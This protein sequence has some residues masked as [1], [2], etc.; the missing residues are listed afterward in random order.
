[1]EIFKY[2]LALYIFLAALLA[3]LSYGVALSFPHMANYA[4]SAA[5]FIHTFSI[6]IMFLQ[7]L[8]EEP[9]NKQDKSETA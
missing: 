9:I 8:R 7:A 6:F 1:M 4:Y 2:I 5:L 3:A